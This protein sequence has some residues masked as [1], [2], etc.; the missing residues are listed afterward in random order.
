MSVDSTPSPDKK[1]TRF[2]VIYVVLFLATFCALD[3]GYYLTRGTVVEHLLIDTLTVRPAA[4]VINVVAPAASASASGN[5]LLTPFGQINVSGGC[6]GSEGMFLLI[7]AV[8]PFPARRL[9]K[10][11]GVICGVSLMYVMNQLRILALVLSLHWHRDWFE[12][13]HG[14]IAPTCIVVAGCIFF[15]AW[16]NAASPRV[17][18]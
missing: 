5:S 9:S 17:H 16:V 13:L 11:V 1:H 3:Y 8:L 4:A 15:F 7:A 2:G 12:S 6:E 14:L 10:L 18:A